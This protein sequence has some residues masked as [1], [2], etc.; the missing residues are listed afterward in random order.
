MMKALDIL[1]SLV[2]ATGAQAQ[3]LIDKYELS[4]RCGKRAEEV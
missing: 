4:E 2:L 3:S 1:V